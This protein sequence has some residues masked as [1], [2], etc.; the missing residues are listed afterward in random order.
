[1]HGFSS[2]TYEVKQLAE[3]LAEN[4]FHTIANN[5]PGH[6]TNKEECNRV[7]SHHWLDFV[8]K[9]VAKLA[10]SSKKMFVVG[11][12]MGA[13]L[14]LY[15]ASLFPL[16]GF[17]AA[18]AVLRFNKYFSTNFL[19]PLLC[20]IKKYER[21]NKV[22]K[23]KNIKFYGYSHYPLV[24]LNE[25]RKMIKVILPL[26]KKIDSP[27]LIIHSR[28]DLTSKEENVKIITEK[29]SKKKIET[30]YV[31]NAHHNMFDKNIDQEKIFKKILNFLNRH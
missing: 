4:N 9:D 15:L 23:S 28:A 18:G 16:N 6:G 1:M 29:I 7:K 19:V 2:T 11:N 20:K 21:K 24:A 12:S 10:S 8:K 30:Y 31:D 5:L 26:I 25:Y 13:V 27:G 14:S 17:V 22:I 3:Y